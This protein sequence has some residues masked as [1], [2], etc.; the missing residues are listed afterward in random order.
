MKYNTDINII[1]SIPDYNLIYRALPLLISNP[2]EIEV[3]LV[4]NNEYDFRTEKSRK[5]FLTALKSAFVNHQKAELNLLIGKLIEKFH[6]D[7]QSQAILIFWIFN[8]Q[9]NL[10]F[11]LNQFLF[12]NYYYQG[13]SD[14]PKEDVVAY[15]KD[16]ISRT[17]ELKGKWSEITID[18][19]ASKYLTILKKLDLL[20]GNQK[21]KYK[22]IYISDEMLAIY[23]HLID[24]MKA[25]NSN[26][27]DNEYIQ[28]VFIDKTN[29][30]DRLKKVAKK[31]WINMQV[32]GTT[33]SVKGKFNSKTIIDGIFG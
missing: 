15:I 33:F 20:E 16:L 8:F 26:F 32:T 17:E 21:K 12:L 25:S 6:A 18:T 1:G 14:L 24:I 28:M 30:V 19:I 31:D 5:R 27:I 4:S 10:F 3:F 13:R 7:Q 29:L 9:N 23:V 2:K 22:Y 11:E